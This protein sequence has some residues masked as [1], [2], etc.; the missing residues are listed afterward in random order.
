ML[1]YLCNVLH[2]LLV[3]T[4]CVQYPFLCCLPLSGIDYMLQAKLAEGRA[5]EAEQKLEGTN[6]SIYYLE[7][8][9]RLSFLLIVGLC[10]NTYSTHTHTHTHTV[11]QSELLQSQGEVRLLLDR[12]GEASRDR[13][14]M[15]SSKVHTQLLQVADDR[16]MSAERQTQAL[17]REVRDNDLR[18]NFQGCI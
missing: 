1:V 14:E 4:T 13:S 3:A 7:L 2:I 11:L 5:R 16:A 12:V 15:I 8:A 9:V 10:G 18:T 6:L 17:E